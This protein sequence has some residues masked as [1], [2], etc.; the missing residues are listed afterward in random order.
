MLTGVRRLEAAEASWQEIDLGSRRWVIPA[1]RM[2][3]RPGKAKPHLVPI[4]PAIEA[5]LN[6]TPRFTG[7]QYL[8][9][10]SGGAKALS[11]FSKA[12]HDLDEAMKADLGD[13]FRP[14]VIHDVRR[15]CRTK[16]SEIGIPEHIAERLLAHAVPEIERRYNLHGF[17]KEKAAALERWHSHLEGIVEGRPNN[18]VQLRAS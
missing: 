6:E 18:V 3:A 2:K 7:G 9:S 15:T 5:L 8:F 10:N 13:A 1:E 16:F 11:A 14:F 17:E 12:K 4:T